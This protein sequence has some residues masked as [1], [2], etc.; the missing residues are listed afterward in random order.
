MLLIPFNRVSYYHVNT[1]N[2]HPLYSIQE[3]N[4]TTFF[5]TI[6]L[7]FFE[8]ISINW[9]ENPHSIHIYKTSSISQALRGT[10]KDIHE[11]DIGPISK[12]FRV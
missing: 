7:M 8:L 2:T 5:I 12:D 10:V 6:L 11:A 1:N 4:F 9:T 3:I